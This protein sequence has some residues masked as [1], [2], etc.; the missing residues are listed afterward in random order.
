MSMEHSPVY[1]GGL[2]TQRDT[3]MFACA[4]APIDAILAQLAN[5]D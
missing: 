5:V 1:G 3:P 4:K 2:Y